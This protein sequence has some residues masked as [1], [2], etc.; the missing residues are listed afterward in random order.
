MF[1]KCLDSFFPGI[2]LLLR[3]SQLFVF[4]IDLALEKTNLYT[5]LVLFGGCL[6]LYMI[7]PIP[8]SY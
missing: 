5:L 8:L 1:T 2:Y 6:S 7:S 3:S 4:L